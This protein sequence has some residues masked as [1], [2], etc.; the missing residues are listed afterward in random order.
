MWA[1]R[2][3]QGG[4]RILQTNFFYGSKQAA[5]NGSIFFKTEY[6]KDEGFRIFIIKQM[7]VKDGEVT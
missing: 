6:P 7:E 4:E 5:R 1:I 3:E 2:V